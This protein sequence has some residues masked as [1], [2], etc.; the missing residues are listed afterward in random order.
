MAYVRPQTPDRDIRSGH[1]AH[2]TSK[3][4]ITENATLH[5][6]KGGE[7]QGQKLNQRDLQNC[8]TKPLTLPTVSF[9]MLTSL[10]ESAC[11]AA[12]DCAMM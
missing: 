8:T 12:V 2:T 10:V 6:A 9:D 4:E 11:S 5:T 1:A 3:H 7:M